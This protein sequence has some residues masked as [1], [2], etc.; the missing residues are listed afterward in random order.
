MGAVI[1]RSIQIHDSAVKLTYNG[2]RTS[3]QAL[4]AQASEGSKHHLQNGSFPYARG[5]LGQF[6][7]G[8]SI[9]SSRDAPHVAVVTYSK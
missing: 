6:S 1:E 7:N 4:M 8:G 2:V 5:Y 3:L 9:A